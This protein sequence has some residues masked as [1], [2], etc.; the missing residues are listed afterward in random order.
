MYIYLS[1]YLFVS[2]EFRYSYIYLW[3]KINPKEVVFYL[4]IQKG[5]TWNLFGKS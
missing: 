4:S 5:L 2:I 1:I 3:N